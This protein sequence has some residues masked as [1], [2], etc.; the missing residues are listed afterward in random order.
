MG[1][2][3]CAQNPVLWSFCQAKHSVMM[4]LNG[5]DV[6]FGLNEVKGSNKGHG[7]NQSNVI[8]KAGDT[9]TLDG[10]PSNTF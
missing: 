9:Y 4:T 8:K 5:S 6:L 2:C 7:R 3:R 10:S 1:P